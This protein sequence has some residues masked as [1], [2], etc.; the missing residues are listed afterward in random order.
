[1]NAPRGHPVLLSSCFGHKWRA[2]HG[3]EGLRVGACDVNITP[4]FMGA[5]IGAIHAV[6]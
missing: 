3:P 2:A 1:M 5:I 6:K 4:P